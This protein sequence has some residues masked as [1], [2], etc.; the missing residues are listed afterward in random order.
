MTSFIQRGPEVIYHERYL[1]ITDDELLMIPFTSFIDLGKL[2]WGWGCS[3]VVIRR[4]HTKRGCIGVVFRRHRAKWGCSKV[5]IRRHRFDESVRRSFS[6]NMASANGA[7]KS[8]WQI[9]RKILSPW[10]GSEYLDDKTSFSNSRFFRW[11]FTVAAWDAL[12]FMPIGM[13]SNFFF[14][15]FSYFHIEVYVHLYQYKLRW[16][17][18]WK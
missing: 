11:S 1:I 18:M 4:H 14:S 17:S 13:K 2:K 9:R 7:Q 6:K 5:V 15:F 16:T 10:E 8:W 12:M 3:E